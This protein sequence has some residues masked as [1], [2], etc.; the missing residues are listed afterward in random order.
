MLLLDVIQHSTLLHLEAFEIA[1]KE[2]PYAGGSQHCGFPEKYHLGQKHN[3]ELSQFTG[4]HG[5]QYLGEIEFT[6]GL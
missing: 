4:G 1:K 6:K 3:P 5:N 2:Y